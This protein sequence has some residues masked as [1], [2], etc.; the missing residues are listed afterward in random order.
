MGD[1]TNPI[2]GNSVTRSAWSNV[3]QLDGDPTGDDV[4]GHSGAATPQQWSQA[5]SR[6][7]QTLAGQKPANVQGLHGLTFKDG[8]PR[9]GELQKALVQTGDLDSKFATG[10]LNPETLKAFKQFMNEHHFQP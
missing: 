6:R 8:D 4:Q 3:A 1:S 9:I 7:A 5:L 10:K 2:S